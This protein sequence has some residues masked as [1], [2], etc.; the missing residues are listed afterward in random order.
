MSGAE[1]GALGKVPQPTVAPLASAAGVRTREIL[2]IPIAI[3]DYEQAMDVMDSMV[4]QREPGYVCAAPVHAV[5][6]AQDDPE[7]Y[8]A[9]RRSTLTVPDGMPLVWAARLQGAPVPERVAGSDVT[10][11][12]AG[13]AA[14]ARASV[15]L[16]GGAP[17]T[18]ELAAERLR[19]QFPGLVVAGVLSP[20]LGFE[21]DPD[22]LA[23]IAAAL[24]VARP[25]IVFVGLGF[26]KQEKLIEWLRP[27]F[28]DTWFMSVGGSLDF[29]AGRIDRAPRWMQAAGLEWLH[30]LTHEPRRLFKRYILLDL[31]FALRLYGHVAWTRSKSRLV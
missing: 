19:R 4:E 7:M 26:P 11:S 12:L 25:S 14:R 15:Y 16:L 5:M 21:R 8:E 24:T 10:W 22:Q 30:R 6:V 13:A 18:A 31:P 3:T 2:R 17:G 28:P 27:R 1:T 23:V 29:I 9:L 20:P